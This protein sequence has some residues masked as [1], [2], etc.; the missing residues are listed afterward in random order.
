MADARAEKL[1][2]VG[3]SQSAIWQ[4]AGYL[5]ALGW[6]PVFYR[7]IQSKEMANSPSMKSESAFSAFA[8]AGSTENNDTSILSSDGH[9]NLP[10]IDVYH[11]KKCCTDSCWNLLSQ[12]CFLIGAWLVH[13]IR[14][15]FN[16]KIFYQKVPCATLSMALDG[17]RLQLT[18][19]TVDSI[20]TIIFFSFVLSDSLYRQSIFIVLW[21]SFSSSFFACV[22]L[23]A[24]LFQTSIHSLEFLPVSVQS[25]LNLT[26]C[27]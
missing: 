12:F 24:C 19:L 15:Q 21:F 26:G 25:A 7:N 23:R 6:Q 3:D 11:Q 16:P 10:G 17:E 20:T 22:L 13:W 27:I 2:F 9:H 5:T 8:P 18:V 4:P 14:I 1:R